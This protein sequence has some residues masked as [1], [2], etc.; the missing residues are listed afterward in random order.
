M[1]SNNTN[2][3]YQVPGGLNQD[4]FYLF[5]DRLRDLSSFARKK[6]EISTQNALGKPIAITAKISDL[7]NDV[8]E[9]YPRAGSTYLKA[10]YQISRDAFCDAVEMTIG[11]FNGQKFDPST[12]DKNDYLALMNNA[13]EPEEI[14]KAEFDSVH[15][16]FDKRTKS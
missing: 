2:F 16:N 8:Y 3:K 11:F 4:R 9:I 15:F 7:E 10:N 1:K 13:S 14:T 6:L 5:Q 12:K